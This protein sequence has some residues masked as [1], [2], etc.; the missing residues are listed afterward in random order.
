MP[1]Q[2]SQDVEEV[3]YG[4]SDSCERL[5]S[6]MKART[7]ALKGVCSV[8]RNVTFILR[9]MQGRAAQD[10]GYAWAAAAA[11]QSAQSEFQALPEHN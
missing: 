3:L 11:F 1:I 8:R 4:R 7:R 2:T 5:M 6:L 9:G 10:A